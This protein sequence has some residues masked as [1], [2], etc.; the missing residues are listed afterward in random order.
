MW[1]LE[2]LGYGKNERSSQQE[3]IDHD[4]IIIS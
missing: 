1:W 4:V 3:I 2:V